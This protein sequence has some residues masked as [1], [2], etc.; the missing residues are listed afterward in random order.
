M[1]N[2]IK[3]LSMLDLDGSNR[4]QFLQDLFAGLKEY[5]F[6][7]LKD[8]HIKR[9]Q[10]D[11]AYKL[12]KEFFNLPLKTKLQYDS[13]SGGA[14]GYTAFGRENAKGNPHADLK[15]FWHVG[16][17]VTADSPY[18]EEYPKNTWPSELPEFQPV[19]Q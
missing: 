4:Q 2:E 7:V 19:F 3:H 6:V 11:H 13:G 15:E 14:R 8:H 16:Q 17:S 18:Y 1:S 9:S 10:L 5:G 12:A